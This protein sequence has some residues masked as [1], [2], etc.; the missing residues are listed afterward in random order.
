MKNNSSFIRL[1][2]AAVMA[3]TIIN[4]SFASERY[5]DNTQNSESITRTFDVSKGFHVISSDVVGC[6]IFVQTKDEA[7]K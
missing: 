2:F 7:S 5:S 1:I 3:L 6:V 4:T